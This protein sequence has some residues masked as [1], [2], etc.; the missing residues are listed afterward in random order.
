MENHNVSIRKILLKTL[1]GGFPTTV[2]LSTRTIDIGM[3]N[4]D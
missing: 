2:T 3:E 1:A 4:K